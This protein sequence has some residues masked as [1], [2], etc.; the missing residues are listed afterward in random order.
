MSRGH[1]LFIFDILYFFTMQC[2]QNNIL[3]VKD[4][5]DAEKMTFV[6]LFNAQIY[7]I[8]EEEKTCHGD[9]FFLNF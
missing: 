2:P 7:I 1:I 3:T 6:P 5:I 4:V 8:F 9:T